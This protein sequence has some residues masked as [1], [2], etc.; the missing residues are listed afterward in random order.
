MSIIEIKVETKITL[1]LT[2]G[3]A[4]ALQAICGYGPDI[5]LKWFESTHG[6]HYIGPYKE[7][8]PS[9]FKKARGLSHVVETVERELK[10]I[11]RKIKC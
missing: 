9:L 6:K 5:F 8:V 10:K 2:A 4:G 7:H 3:E 1:E 11:P